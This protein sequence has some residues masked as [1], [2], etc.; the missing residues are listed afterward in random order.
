MLFR[1]S[2]INNA[3]I[4]PHAINAPIFGITMEDKNLPNLCTPFFIKSFSFHYI[5]FSYGTVKNFYR[6]AGTIAK[7]SADSCYNK[8]TPAFSHCPLNCSDTFWSDTTVLTSS[9]WQIWNVLFL[10]ILDESI[11][12]IFSADCCSTALFK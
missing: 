3:V 1:S 2:A 12:M 6:P 10:S 11:N 8:Y 5:C 9:I 7:Q 4:K